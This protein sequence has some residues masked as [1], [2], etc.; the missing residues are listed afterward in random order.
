MKGDNMRSI[1]KTIKVKVIEAVVYNRV[2]KE[3]KVINVRL[4]E[5]K[6]NIE[7]PENCFLLEQKTISEKEVVYTMTPEVFF[8]NATIEE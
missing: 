2:T 8:E 5:F 3:E 4:P 1:R 7:M 6:E